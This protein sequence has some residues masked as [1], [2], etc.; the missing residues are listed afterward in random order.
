MKSTYSV[1]L[2][3]AITAVMPLSAVTTQPENS[4]IDT[5][6]P[7][8]DPQL[9]MAL[10]NTATK[11]SASLTSQ[12]VV[13]QFQDE[14]TPAEIAM[15]ERNG[16]EF[17]RHGDSVVHVGCI[18]SARAT[19]TSAINAL[20]SLGLLRAVSGEKQYV[21]SLSSSV[22]A[23]H[24]P[25]VWNNLLSNGESINGTGVSVAVIDTGIALYHPSFWR[26]TTGEIDVIQHGSDFYVDF[27]GDAVADANEGPIN[28]IDIQIEETVEVSNEYLFIDIGDN[29]FNLADGDLWLG[30]VDANDNNRIDFPTENVVVFG[31]SKVSILYDQYTGLVYQ[32]GVNLTSGYSVSDSYGHGTH[33]ASTIAGG[34]PGFTSYVGVAPG[35]DLIIIRSLLTSS[36]IIDAIHFAVAS[37]ADIINM[38]FSSYLGF[39]DGTDI[40]DL[41]ITEAFR[42]HGV[43]TTAAAGNL[44]TISKHA[45]LTVP[46]NTNQT[47]SLDVYSPPDSSYLSFL[48]H[49]SDNDEHIILRPPT[50]DSIDLG[51]FSDLL[52]GSYMLSTPQIN[53]YMFADASLRGLNNILIQISEPTHNWT[54]GIWSV[55]MRNPGGD[56][57]EVDI[58]AWDG[59]WDHANFQFID[60]VDHSRTISSPGTADLAIA[61]GNY[62][63]GGG[64]VSSTSSKGPRIDGVPKPNIVAPGTDITAAST[65]LSGT[66]RLWISRSGTSMASPHV[67]G[68]LALIRQASN[69]TNG[70]LDY[71]ALI[72]GAGHELVHY[73]IPD[74]SWGHGLCDA[75]WSVQHVNEIQFETPTTLDSW[76]GYPTVIQS[77]ENLSISGNLDLRGIKAHQSLAELALAIEFRDTPDFSSEN[78][79]HLFWDI[80]TDT[81]TG[82][83]GIDI[84][85]NVT[86]GVATVYEWDGDSFE[87]STLDIDFWNDAS[88]LYV[89]LNRPSGDRSSIM[90]ATGNETYAYV[91]QTPLMA[92]LDQWHPLVNDLSLNGNETIFEIS[93]TIDDE[94]TAEEHLGA[95]WEV[96]DGAMTT[97]LQGQETGTNEVAITLDRGSIDNDFLNTIWLNISDSVMSFLLPPVLLSTS[98]LSEMRI[99]SAYIDQTEI[100]VGPFLSQR[101]TG[102]I[103]VEGYALV[104]EVK[105]EFRSAAA[106]SI[107]L[108]LE[109]I[110]GLYP[111]NLIPSI[112]A[113]EYQ[114]YAV[115]EGLY[116]QSVELHMGTLLIIEDNSVIVLM[117]SV[118]FVVIAAAYFMPRLLSKLRGKPRLPT[119]IK[120]AD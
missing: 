19:T 64:G 120:G 31:E 50:G 118:A 96:D 44:G 113:G 34:Q 69:N 56:E 8:I 94:D 76:V 39:L 109:G 115:A 37:G 12:R 92:L 45:Y 21:P 89:R 83:G 18:Y 59:D 77:P 30:G 78:I 14:L 58:Y 1:L 57:V 98:S 51:T 112:A 82:E 81:E 107:G 110:D 28:H 86:G 48:W 29:G 35:A 22:P 61:V 100:R 99:A 108:V 15:A 26:Q 5:F 68:L 104:E 43:L 10:T 32:R 106:F 2:L 66:S 79:L 103:I 11:E 41:A 97:L 119:E 46:A 13:L 36:D 87:V 47:A 90:L 27:D 80:D 52:G 65:R 93:L 23:I 105:I 4:L 25:S 33:V 16:L 85:A 116:G 88:S 60:H 74:S 55:G 38:S 6:L 73:S 62:N 114:V 84:M 63:D 67:A 102:Q 95:F 75:V 54:S 3:L 101:L 42:R 40:E 53:A 71:S 9:R 20:S 72:A 111:I 17:S 7:S 70:W 117:A 91:D 49:S 24:A